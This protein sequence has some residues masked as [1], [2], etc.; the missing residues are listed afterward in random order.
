MYNAYTEKNNLR[1]KGKRYLL[2]PNP[3][4]EAQLI[5][6]RI[7]INKKKKTITHLQVV[8]NEEQ[9]AL[10]DRIHTESKHAGKILIFITLTIPLLIRVKS[11]STFCN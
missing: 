5:L 8:T 9:D 6:F 10:Y 1:K 4:N 2:K 3:I 11:K 7:R